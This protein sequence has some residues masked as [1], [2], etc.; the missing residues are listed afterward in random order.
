MIIEIKEDLKKVKFENKEHRHLTLLLFMQKAQSFLIEAGELVG[1]TDWYS[2]LEKIFYSLPDEILTP[3]GYSKNMNSL[4]TIDSLITHTL[5][6]DV[7]KL[8]RVTLFKDLP[9][10]E[11]L[12]F[13]KIKEEIRSLN[14]N[15]SI[16]RNK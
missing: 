6:N 14:I 9:N 5:T 15:S 13:L 8:A 1:D 16:W 3:C 12:S 4:N 10:V 7:L 2:K 11:E